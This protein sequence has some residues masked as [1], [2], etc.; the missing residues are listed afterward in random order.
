M[1]YIDSANHDETSK[2][3]ILFNPRSSSFEL[4]CEDG[5]PAPAKG[6]EIFISYGKRGPTDLL[7]NFGIVEGGK[8]GKAVGTGRQALAE[9][10]ATTRRTAAK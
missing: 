6:E 4:V 8:R 7:V 2:L 1:P 5:S 10:F 3:E 9:R